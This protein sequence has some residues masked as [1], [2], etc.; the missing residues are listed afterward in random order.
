MN[1]ASTIVYIVHMGDFDLY[2]VG[3]TSPERMKDRLRVLQ[4]GNPFKLK[5]IFTE[6]HGPEYTP[7]VERILLRSL[8][9]YQTDI[10]EWFFVSKDILNEF[11][12]NI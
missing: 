3:I 9:P 4:R 7:M 12:K 8:K 5:Y 10:K 6:Y 1:N 2:K 11:I